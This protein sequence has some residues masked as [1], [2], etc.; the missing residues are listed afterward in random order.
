[1]FVVAISTTR[2]SQEM[3][4]LTTLGVVP[5]NEVRYVRFA[6]HAF[7]SRR[8]GRDPVVTECQ[9]RLQASSIREVVPFN[10]KPFMTKKKGSKN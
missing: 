6:Y 2:S 3:Q 8:S 4:G 1:M 7:V 9:F 5:N 10:C